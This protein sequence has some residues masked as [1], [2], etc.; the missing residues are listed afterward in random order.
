MSSLKGSVSGI[1]RG[2]YMSVYVLLILLNELGIRD[3]TRGLPRILSLFFFAASLIY[4][5]IHDSI[6][7]QMAFRLL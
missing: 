1:N 2:S 3:K 5:I 6:L 7:Y 4:S